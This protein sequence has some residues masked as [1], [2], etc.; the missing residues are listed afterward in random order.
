MLEIEE[1]FNRMK[2]VVLIITY[3]DG[4]FARSNSD[5]KPEIDKILKNVGELIEK[6]R[7]IVRDVEPSNDMT[8]LRFTLKKHEI[9]I[10]PGKNFRIIVVQEINKDSTTDEKS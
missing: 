4:S 9:I 10:A 5:S 3:A 6:A 8:L 1:A 2:K 7:T